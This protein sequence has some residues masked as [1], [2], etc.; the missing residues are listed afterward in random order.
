MKVIPWIL[1]LLLG[2]GVYFFHSKAKEEEGEVASLREEIEH[3]ESKVAELEEAR[4]SA[5]NAD[6]YERLRKQADEVYKL[7]GEISQLRRENQQ[8]AL[9]A[10]QQPQPI[11]QAVVHDPFFDEDFPEASLSE[12]ELAQLRIQRQ[13]ATVCVEH[14]KNLEEAKTKWATSNN[15]NG[16]EQV[17]A[18]EVLAY[19]PNQTM[20]LCPSGGTYTFNE[21]G[22][23]ASCSVEGHS[24]LP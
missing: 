11:A 14:L 9:K 10:Q 12:Q 1:V 13:H 8:F 15:K 24:L 2:G 19:V 22:I 6:E 5:I 3:L 23:P 18:N 4:N 7:R 20:P 21:I 17:L 16:G